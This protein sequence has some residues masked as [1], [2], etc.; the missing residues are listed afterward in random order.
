MTMVN[1][2]KGMDDLQCLDYSPLAL[3]SDELVPAQ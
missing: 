2:C 3:L 1:Y